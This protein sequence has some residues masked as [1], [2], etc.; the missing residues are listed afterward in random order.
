MVVQPSESAE[1]TS[2]FPPALPFEDGRR[3]FGSN[4]VPTTEG[5]SDE[6][7]VEHATSDWWAI[8]SNIADLEERLLNAKSSIAEVE[9]CILLGIPAFESSESAKRRKLT[10]RMVDDIQLSI[11][12]IETKPRS[13]L[14]E[15]TQSDVIRRL[16]HVKALF[17]EYLMLPDVGATKD[18]KA[19]K[20]FELLLRKILEKAPVS[21]S[22]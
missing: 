14:A 13:R 22:Q 3:E 20:H 2:Y 10:Q 5:S 11:K 19:Y 16:S 7:G 9:K 12:R 1:S 8:P 6:S 4:G 18:A 21:L 17:D 15:A